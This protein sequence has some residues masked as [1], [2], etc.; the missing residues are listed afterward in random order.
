MLPFLKASSLALRRNDKVY[1]VNLFRSILF[2]IRNW[3][4]SDLSSTNDAWWPHLSAFVSV[5]LLYGI[6]PT[7]LKKGYCVIPVV[8]LLLEFVNNFSIKD[9]DFYRLLF[10]LKSSSSC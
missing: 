1:F 2:V 8:L 3:Q 7:F 5:K 6:C 4:D 10:L 9:L